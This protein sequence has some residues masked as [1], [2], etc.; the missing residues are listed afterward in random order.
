M[1][2]RVKLLGLAAAVALCLGFAA[3]AAVNADPIASTTNLTVNFTEGG[4]F[5]FGLGVQTGFTNGA[6]TASTAAQD[7]TGTLR[8]TYTDT[9]S[10]RSGFNVDLSAGN[11]NSTLQV[12]YAPTGTVYSIP[13]VNLTLTKNYNPQQD[14]WTSQG[15]GLTP[16]GTFPTSPT[17]LWAYRVGDI[18]AT[19]QIGGSIN[20]ANFSSW[21]AANS[22]DT[23]RFVA[24]GLAG[25][26]TVHT[27]QDL[28]V[29]L[30]V[31][32]AMPGVVYTSIVTATLT[33]TTP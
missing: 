19:T 25:S 22:L 3:P 15:C 30:H 4:A 8:I 33:G 26:G 12:P 9:Q 6:V 18:G 1:N 20:P 13:A 7:L 2:L 11:F 23:A 32:A 5:S 14:R 31:P 28:D 16:G 27:T 21:T 29:S 17:C 24:Y 10:Y